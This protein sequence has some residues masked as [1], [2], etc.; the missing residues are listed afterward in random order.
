MYLHG[1]RQEALAGWRTLA[2]QFKQPLDAMFVALVADGLGDTAT[3]DEFL[4]KAYER[5]GTSDVVFGELVRALR[6]D[7]ANGSLDVAELGRFIRQNSFS[8]AYAG[9]RLYL[10]AWY[11][12]N[13]GREEEA[14][15][16]CKIVASAPDVDE[17]TTVLAGRY[18][19]THGHDP[20]RRAGSLVSDE[21]LHLAALINDGSRLTSSKPMWA[22]LRFDEVLKAE[23]RHVVGLQWRAHVLTQQERFHDAVSDYDVLIAEMPRTAIH[24]L[25]RGSL[26][27]RLGDEAK[28]VADF[29]L[30]VDLA[31]S[32]K[33]R[34]LLSNGL[35]SLAMMH[36]AGRDSAVFGPRT[37]IAARRG[38]DCP[39]TR[40]RM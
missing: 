29:E 24:Y 6:E 19:T 25:G 35:L 27:A 30:A 39:G 17:V 9:S 2:E 34:S 28:A 31:Q 16:Y 36:A 12:T 8:S 11:L 3:R 26:Y 20:V 14:L 22:L 38:S 7:L 37:G 1:Q 5:C 32:Q 33:M 40:S 18:L 4:T 15:P 13:R 10:L 21:M 23:P